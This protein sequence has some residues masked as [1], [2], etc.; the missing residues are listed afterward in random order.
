VGETAK[1]LAT[2]AVIVPI[3]VLGIFYDPT[4]WGVVAIGTIFALGALD[5]YLRMALPVSEADPA[6]GLRITMALLCVAIVVLPSL[7]SL[8]DVMPP[9]LTSAV[10]VIG[11]AILARR[12]QLPDG[13]RHFGVAL[14]G[15]LYV[16]VL[17]SVLPLLKKAG[18][19]E[20]LA[21]TLVMAFFSDT[22]AYF[23]GRALGK[24]KLYPAVSPGKTIEGSIGGILAACAGTVGIGSMWVLPDL[25]ISHAIGLGVAASVC[26]Q[27][28]DLVESLLK[29]TF[30]VKDSGK[31]L[32]GHGG[33]LDRID[34]LLFVAPIAY[35]YVALVG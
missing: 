16:P 2:A 35:Y 31:V 28:G 9:L 8:A 5:E 34:A 21:V 24:H 6:I 27:M 23:A 22:G 32:P 30:D 29:R 17:M 10:V 3:L 19:A 13:G 33:M 15:V 12:K 26:G 18:H 25:P 4:H 1:R 7:Y 14:S 20:W 11:F